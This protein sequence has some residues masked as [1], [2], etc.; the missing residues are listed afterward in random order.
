[1]QDEDGPR[2]NGTE[3]EGTEQ[4]QGSEAVED[5]SVD[6]EARGLASAR[7]FREV[8]EEQERRSLWRVP[9]WRAEACADVGA[10]QLEAVDPELAA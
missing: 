3:G 10:D 1:M 9:P 2:L 8:Q 4:Q 5:D 6:S 7:E